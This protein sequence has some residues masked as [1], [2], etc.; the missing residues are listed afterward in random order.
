M[1][2]SGK[3][4]LVAYSPAPSRPWRFHWQVKSRN[5]QFLEIVEDLEKAAAMLPGKETTSASTSFHLN[6]FSEG[7]SQAK[8]QIHRLNHRGPAVAH[9]EG[10][11]HFDD[12]TINK[13]R[14]LS[15]RIRSRLN[16]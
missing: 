8:D 4:R 14:I 12:E 13:M 2:P 15:R 11:H 9:S 1:V 16:C 7:H 6:A 5:A 10:H 3:L